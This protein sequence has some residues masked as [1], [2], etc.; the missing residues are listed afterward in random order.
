MTQ[1]R[2]LQRLIRKYP[3]PTELHA[4]VS[5]AFYQ[6]DEDR[7]M[8]ER[9]LQL[10]SDELNQINAELKSKIGSIEAYQQELELS[11][12]RKKALLDA[13]LEAVFSFGSQGQV[14]AVN[15]AGCDFFQLSE[16]SL[17]CMSY[18]AV[19][20]HLFSLLEDL[21]PLVESLDQIS[22]SQ[23]QQVKGELQT[24]DG[25]TYEYVSVAE[26]LGGKYVGRVWCC[27]DTTAYSQQQAALL[28]QAYHDVLT[29]LPNRLL[30]KETIN[31][32]MDKS[33]RAGQMV[34]LL[35]IDLD[36]F[37]KINDT[38]GHGEGD[39]F[40][41]EVTRRLK[42]TLRAGDTLGRL[43]GD[44]FLIVIDQ[45]SGLEQVEK[46]AQRII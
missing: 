27:R 10:T 45:V 1:H 32:A 26:I 33:K 18:D 30:L 39:K 40:L 24:K 11:L 21:Q 35:Y 16:A 29:G 34:A 17:K 25:K 4:A 6:F 42:Q 38:E 36:D 44:E 46:T 9:S 7:L 8:L 28:H 5:K 23:C 22:K 15:R 13:S 41:C 14:L 19:L 3:N 43:S 2:L 31:H 20:K 37:K 12:T